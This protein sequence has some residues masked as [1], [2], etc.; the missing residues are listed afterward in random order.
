MRFAPFSL[1]AGLVF[2]SILAVGTQTSF[3]AEEKPAAVPEYRFEVGQE[4]F[5]RGINEYVYA[6]G[7]FLNADTW[8]FLVVGRK[9]DGAWQ[10]L[11]RHASVSGRV[12][13]DKDADAAKA[14]LKRAAE[15]LGD[16][17][18]EAGRVQRTFGRFEINRNG[19][20]SGSSVPVWISPPLTHLLTSLPETISQASA[21]WDLKDRSTDQTFTCHYTRTPESAN[22]VIESKVESVEDDLFQTVRSI[23]TKFDRKRGVPVQITS[24]AIQGYGVKGRETQTV[25]LVEIKSHSLEW[26]DVC[27]T[28]SARCFSV[29]DD[30][31]Q[32]YDSHDL[33]SKRMVEGLKN[34]CVRLEQLGETLRT[35]EL[36]KAMK[37][38]S[39]QLKSE[40]ESKVKEVEQRDE[41]IGTPSPD[42]RTTDLAGKEYSSKDLRGK[43]IVL[44]FWYRGCGWCIR[45][46]PQVNA[47]SKHFKDEQVVV[48][49]MNK[50]DTLEVATPVIERLKLEYPQLKAEKICE[51]YKIRGFPTLVILDQ[52]GLI[53]DVHV[54]YSPTLK[55]DVIR[56]VELL[57][58][59]KP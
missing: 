48:F 21:G 4:L 38:Q 40:M 50:H 5:Y 3:A 56:S 6:R 59:A 1:A 22:D 35:D 49:G 28:E 18:N 41:M 23:T 7:S 45:A 17:K 46:M 36:K 24:E 19:R 27:A 57:M 34:C 37:D 31:R 58:K 54:G 43:V 8:R 15:T 51:Q 12:G 52:Q 55:D 42:W 16:G 2:L 32:I 25:E 53:R 9:P 10:V 44:D 39:I 29:I 11:I 20:I 47:V 33:K 14:E 13:K 26:N 30:F